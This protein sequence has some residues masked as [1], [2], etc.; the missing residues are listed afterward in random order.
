M[1]SHEHAMK[2][3]RDN[4]KENLGA[5]IDANGDNVYMHKSLVPS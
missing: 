2:M 4:V 1:V 5:K 3:Q